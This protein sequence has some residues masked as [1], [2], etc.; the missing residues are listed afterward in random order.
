[1]VAAGPVEDVLTAPLL[2]DA[3]GVPLEVQREDGRYGAR[4]ATQPAVRAS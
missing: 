4:R 3:F 2:S 1:V